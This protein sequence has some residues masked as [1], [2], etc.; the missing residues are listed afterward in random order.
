MQHSAV[1][2]KG[3]NLVYTRPGRSGES[4]SRAAAS[5]C[6][7]RARR[8]PRIRELEGG[9]LNVE[10]PGQTCLELVQQAGHGATRRSISSKGTGPQGRS[11]TAPPPIAPDVGQHV[12]GVRQQRQRPGRIAVI[13]SASVSW[14]VGRYWLLRRG[15]QN[16]AGSLPGW[17]PGGRRTG[18]LAARIQA[19]VIETPNRA[20]H[21]SIPE[22]VQD[23]LLRF[24]V[25]VGRS[26]RS[27]YSVVRPVSSRWMACW[28]LPA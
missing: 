5:G 25:Q 23:V 20:R 17:E 8:G 21:G 16:G 22:T 28:P 10:M 6:R 1:S 7:A 27:R 15:Y 26:R 11:P 9:V 12:P 24:W 3:L 13:T 14:L 4:S 19:V 2:G 18:G